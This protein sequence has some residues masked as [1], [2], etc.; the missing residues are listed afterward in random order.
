[1][2]GIEADL[3]LPRIAHGWQWIGLS[4]YCWMRNCS[5]ELASGF[6][7]THTGEEEDKDGDE[8]LTT[9][10]GQIVITC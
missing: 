10:V 1:M 9:H 3:L 8:L 2:R 6:R 7:E 4:G 5:R